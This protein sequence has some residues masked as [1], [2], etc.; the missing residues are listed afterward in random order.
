MPLVVAHVVTRLVTDHR[1]GLYISVDSVLPHVQPVLRSDSE[2]QHQLIVVSQHGTGSRQ[3][4]YTTCQATRGQ[5]AWA[6]PASACC[7]WDSAP[8]Q[9]GPLPSNESAQEGEVYILPT[10]CVNEG[11]QMAAST[12]M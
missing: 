2:A 10:I 5:S 4:Q 6:V 9:P 11:H 7:C 12:Q 1:Q 8:L 3:L